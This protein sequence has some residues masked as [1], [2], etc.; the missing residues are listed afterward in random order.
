V[1]T[2]FG[3]DEKSLQVKD[4]CGWGYMIE[5]VY[6][7]IKVRENII[8][9]LR[10]TCCTISWTSMGLFLDILE[11]GTGVTQH[12]QVQILNMVCFQNQTW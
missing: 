3:K 11:H 12:G 5:E 6:M 10:R 1:N 2:T 4:Q 8:I 7:T 9:P